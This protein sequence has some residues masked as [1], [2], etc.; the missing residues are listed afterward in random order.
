M[1]GGGVVG[2]KVGSSADSIAELEDYRD[3]IARLL[4]TGCLNNVHTS[5]VNFDPESLLY[6][7]N[8]LTRM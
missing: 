7:R 5:K 1:W 8:H 6:L 3:S 2:G 4:E